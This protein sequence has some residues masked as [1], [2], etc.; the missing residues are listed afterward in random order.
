MSDASS[1][2]SRRRFALVAG[3]ALIAVIAVVVISQSGGDDEDSSSSTA[4]ESADTLE[5]IPQRGFEVGDSDA[6]LTM[7]EYG[8][9][10][11][12]FCAEAGTEVIPS[13]IEDYVA[14]GELRIVFEPLAFVGPDSQTAARF[15][16]AAALQDRGFAFVERFYANQGTENSGY[17]TDDFLEQIAAAVPGLDA[18]EAFAAADTPP[19]QQLLD[20]AEAGA[21]EAGVDSTPTFLLGANEDS[22]ETVNA[23]PGDLD[24]FRDEIDAAPDQ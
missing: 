19:A 14:D 2:D 5:G 21:T 20:D 4:T 16:A 13:L 23:G 6:P 7:V 17:V 3:L 9:L 18:E 24:A 8:D 15:A 10:Q 12:P 22:L 1:T 11:C